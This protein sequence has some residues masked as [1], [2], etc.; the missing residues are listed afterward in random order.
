MEVSP[1]IVS[2]LFLFH[3]WEM[4]TEAPRHKHP[5]NGIN[6]VEVADVV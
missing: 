3:F 2:L 6:K 1:G 5:K 4:S